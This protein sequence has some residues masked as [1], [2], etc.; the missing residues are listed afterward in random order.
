[1]RRSLIASF[2]AVAFIGIL[3]PASSMAVPLATTQVGHVCKTLGVSDDS[4][5]GAALPIVQDSA[6]DQT[7]SGSTAW[8]SYIAHAEGTTSAGFGAIPQVGIAT[9]STLASSDNGTASS[10]LYSNVSFNFQI[11]L[12][13]GQSD[14]GLALIPVSTSAQGVGYAERTGY[15]F[16]E[17]QG[18]VQVNGNHLGFQDVYFAYDAYVVDEIAFDPVDSENQTAI[19]DGTKSANLGVGDIYNVDISSSC[20]SWVAPIGGQS[21][22][23]SAG[24]TAWVDPSFAFDQAAFDQ[25]MGTSTYRLDDYYQI[26]FSPNVPVPESD[27]YA[28]MLAGL[29]LVGWAARRRHRI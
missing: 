22:G 29:A 21:A 8:G 17:S 23:A 10:I 25:Q 28:L 12:I 1:M 9:A 14:P 16:A 15:G 11:Q 13:N 7:S 27:T 24:C 5:Y 2:F 6:C 20:E 26:V 19:L 4:F 3:V 18:S